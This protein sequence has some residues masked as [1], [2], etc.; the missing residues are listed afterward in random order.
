MEKDPVITTLKALGDRNRARIIRALARRPACVCELVYALGLSQPNL[1]RHLHILTEAGL[2]A[3]R[4]VGTWIEYRLT[5]G[6]AA[7][8]IKW[9]CQMA[10]GDGQI[11]GDAKAL[12]RADR[13]RL[14]GTGDV[15]RKVGNRGVKAARRAPRG[16]MS[17]GIRR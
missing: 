13:H 2:V 5:P 7:P 11:A 10:K 6:V 15:K 3:P 16:A 8:V 4:R 9:L 14:C 1:S 17:E 12:A